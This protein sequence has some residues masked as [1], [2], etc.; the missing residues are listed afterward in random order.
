MV[1]PEPGTDG[2]RALAEVPTR[3]RGVDPVGP[4]PLPLG[5]VLGPEH[6]IQPGEEAG[7]VPV[8]GVVVVRVVPVVVLRRRDDLAQGTEP[9]PDVGVLEDR[10]GLQ[11]DECATER[12]RAEPEVGEGD[13]TEQPADRA[14]ERMQVCGR[15]P[16]HALAA[17]VD[18]VEPPEDRDGVHHP[19]RPVADEL[20]DH[21]RLD[22]LQH[23]RLRRDRVADEG[24]CQD[25]DQDDERGRDDH[26]ADRR[27]EP[28]EQEVEHVGAEPGAEETLTPVRGP[29]LLQRE[30]DDAEEHERDDRIED[31]VL[32][33]RPLHEG[34]VKRVCSIEGAFGFQRGALLRAE[35]QQLVEHPVLV[36][37]ERGAGAL[38]AA[39]ARRRAG[40]RCAR[41]GRRRGT[42]WVS[43]T[44]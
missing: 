35:T 13:H 37:A 43:G 27:E 25:A 40:S 42:G 18:A 4:R 7:E 3:D 26:Q 38:V 29:E 36:L 5:Q 28:G 11:H 14:V 39:R 41:R 15:E 32:T 33:L 22:E 2:T 31:H 6:R 9:E 1:P 20:D 44:K 23:F 19:V 24:R 34:L 30:E 10:V 8:P 21:Q 16:V 12:R 17:V